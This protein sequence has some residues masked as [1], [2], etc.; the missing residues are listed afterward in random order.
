[1]IA[2]MCT[3]EVSRKQIQ[4]ET[5]LSQVTVNRWL[6]VLRRRPNNLI[7]ISAYKRT[8]IVGPYTEYYSFGFCEQDVPKPPPLSKSQKNRNA[9]R[10][11][12]KSIV[13]QPEQGVIRHESR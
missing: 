3:R 10:R 9:A 12:R 4:E 6:A 1:M 8:A 2:L 7:Y 11:R 5:G 13:H